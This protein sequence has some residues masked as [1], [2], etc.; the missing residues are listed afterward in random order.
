M[1]ETMNLPEV[2]NCTAVGEYFSHINQLLTDPPPQFTQEYAPLIAAQNKASTPFLSVVMRTQGKRPEMLQEALLSLLGQSDMDFEVILVGH[3]LDEHQ[4][5]VVQEICSQ[6]TPMLQQRIRFV[7]L[8]EGNRTKPL[9][10]GFALS[11]GEYIAVLDD[12]DIVMDHW[13]S[14]F[15]AAAER[16]PGRLLHA[17]VLAQDWMRVPMAS[18]KEALRAVSAPDDCFC[19]PF[20]LMRQMRHNRCPLHGMAFPGYVFREWGMVFDESLSTYEDW[21]YLMRVAVLT[22]VEDIDTPTAIYRKW[23][24]AENAYTVHN[25]DEWKAN[26]IKVQ[27]KLMNLPILLPAGSRGTVSGASI[28]ALG[29]A[30]TRFDFSKTEKSKLYL[31][32]GEGFS[33]A[34]AI[35][36]PLHKSGDMFEVLFEVPEHLRQPVQALR[37]DLTEEGMFVLSDVTCILQYVDGNRTL[38]SLR[39]GTSNGIALDDTVVFPGEDPWTVW[40]ADNRP[41]EYVRITGKAGAVLPAEAMNLM[42][43]RLQQAEHPGILRR[44]L[45]KGKAIVQRRTG[46]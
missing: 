7:E 20:D 41:L 14:S 22:G 44:I 5:K 18:G 12:D 30:P 8:Q 10:Y 17:Y 40:P 32:L 43:E 36:T 25:R 24:N 45:R 26:Y 3:K 1:N 39:Q 2:P 15:R 29:E 42:A 31:D 34:K 37:F 27:E 46:K 33:E 16:A 11:R 6:Q 9:N 35:R 13:V 23:V 21:D 28:A 4:R 19:E 38:Y